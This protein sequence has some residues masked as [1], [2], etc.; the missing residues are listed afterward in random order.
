MMKTK[1]KLLLDW[2]SISIKRNRNEL[3]GKYVLIEN[4]WNG[5]LYLQ[6]KKLRIFL[7]LQISIFFFYFLISNVFSKKGQIKRNLIDLNKFSKDK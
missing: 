5:L 4:N 7:K 1:N 2:H 6:K 3:F